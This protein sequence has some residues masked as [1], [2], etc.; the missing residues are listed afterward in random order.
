MLEHTHL[1][2]QPPDAAGRRAIRDA[3][4][5]QLLGHAGWRARGRESWWQRLLGAELEVRE[6]DDE[7]LVFTV[8]RNWTPWRSQEV[9]DAEGY[10]V[11]RVRMPFLLDRFSECL[12]V[13]RP[14]GKDQSVYRSLEG[15]EL[16]VTHKDGDGCRVTFLPAVFGDP[17]AKMVLLAGALCE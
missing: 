7:P 1:L 15:V 14:A 9:R 4:T 16:G 12:A 8:R 5:G 13:R 17:L 2:V 6:Q 3:H 10:R 11:G